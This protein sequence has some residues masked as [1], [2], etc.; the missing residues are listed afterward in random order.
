ML[1]RVAAV[2]APRTHNRRRVTGSSGGRREGGESERQ[3]PNM[4]RRVFHSAVPLLLFVVWV[5]C[6]TCGP[7]AAEDSSSG[8]VHLPERVGLFLPQKTTVLPKEGAGPGEVKDAFASPSLVSAG[9]VM[10]AFAEGRKLYSDPQYPSA[11][12]LAVDIVGGYLNATEPWSSMLAYITS[13]HWNAHTVFDR[14]NP[15][16][17]LGV[18]QRPTSLSKG[19][20]MFLLVGSHYLTFDSTKQRWVEGG[21]DIH[22]VD[23]EVTLSPEDEPSK[24]VRWGTPQS[25]LGLLAGRAKEL[26]LDGFLGAGGSGIVLESG[27]LVFPLTASRRG[28]K[29]VLVIYSMNEGRSWEVGTG[30][31]PGYCFDPLIAEWDGDLLIVATCVGG[32]NVFRSGDMGNT[33]KEDPGILSRL[34]TSELNPRGQNFVLGD[35]INLIV[36]VRR[37]MLYTQKGFPPGGVKANALYLW[38]TDNNRT[39]PVGPISMDDDTERTV[40]NRLLLSNNMLYLLHERSGQSNDGIF[41]SPLKE[42]LETVMSVAVI[43]PLVD[44]FFSESS[45]HADGLVAFLSDPATPNTWID[46]YRCVNVTDRSPP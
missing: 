15:K 42:E 17:V 44:I 8:D 11:K 26:G 10:V 6:S 31:P 22:L 41:L 19:N 46:M 18:A 12:T 20:K 34:W 3:R 38:V 32:R 28:E 40:A 29:T 21:W 5:C 1:S 13:S 33:W 14:E 2:K 35:L 39:R 23:G 4:S 36:G 30:T 25:L 7:V 43:W 45:I 9:G 24:R 27:W 16:G 37:V